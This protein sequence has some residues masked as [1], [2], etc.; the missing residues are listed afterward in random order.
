MA[1]PLATFSNARL[2]YTA[3]GVRG[4]PEVGY[5]ETPGQ[6][7]LVV[8][9]LKQFSQSEKANYERMI[10]LKVSTDFYKGYLIGYCPLNGSDYKTH[11]YTLD[12]GYV[13]T[14]LRPEGMESPC[15]LEMT[16]GHRE[17]SNAE[18]LDSA[19]VFDDLGIG[20]IL[21]EIVGDRLI[22]QAERY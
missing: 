7:Y 2:L 13:A 22:V 15:R 19:G 4:G 12:G 11:D 9:F 14:G 10:D 3:P 18:L 16:F 20:Q 17:F 6:A 5:R 1:T 8:A 21:R